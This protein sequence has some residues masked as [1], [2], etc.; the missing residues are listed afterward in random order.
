MV[1]PFYTGRLAQPS[2]RSWHYCALVTLGPW[3]LTVY[4]V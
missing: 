3:T 4:G 2:P 1:L